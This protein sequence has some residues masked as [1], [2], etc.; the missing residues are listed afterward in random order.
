[1][2]AHTFEK[3]YGIPVPENIKRYSGHKKPGNVAGFFM[4]LYNVVIKQLLY[5]NN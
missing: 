1:M 4:C 5:S 2:A 3:I